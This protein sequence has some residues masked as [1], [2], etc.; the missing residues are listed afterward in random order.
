[1]TRRIVRAA[2]VVLAVGLLALG[3]GCRETKQEKQARTRRT[4]ANESLLESYNPKAI[5]EF[6]KVKKG[7]GEG[8]K[9]KVYISPNSKDLVIGTLNFGTFVERIKEY[10]GW[11]AVRYYS[12]DGGE[13]YGWIQI[14]QAQFLGARDKKDEVI[15]VEDEHKKK[16]LTLQESD[17]EMMAVLGVPYVTY[18]RDAEHEPKKRFHEGKDAE[19]TDH[20]SLLSRISM[21]SETQRWAAQRMRMLIE[22]S[23]RAHTDYVPI[24]R[25]YYYA[26]DW[27]VKG[28]KGRFTQ[29]LKTADEKRARIAGHF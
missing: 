8:A 17:D 28:E 22:L 26:L 29:Q 13:F 10:R 27:Y 1:M 11:Y 24:I 18:Q 16:H 25:A 6:I 19:G 9:V 3:F 23:N 7:S 2:C 20:V 12:R 14:A 5:K 15:L 21:T 4:R